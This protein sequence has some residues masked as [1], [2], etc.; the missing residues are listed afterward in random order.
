MTGVAEPIR[1]WQR[2]SDGQFRVGVVGGGSWGTT[3]AHLAAIA[4]HETRLWVRREELAREI[5]GSHRSPAYTGDV[6]IHPRVKATTDLGEMRECFL[7]LVAIP[8]QAF[9]LVVRDLGDHVD[10][11]HVVV[12]ATKG[13]E[14]MS[15]LTMTEVLLQETCCRKVGVL[16]GPNLSAEI[17]AGQPAVTV[18]GSHFPEVVDATRYGLASRQF[19]LYGNDDVVGV[20]VAGALKNVIA[21]ASGYVAGLGL[22]DNTRAGLLTRGMAEIARI[23]IHLGARERTFSG[24]SGIGDLIATC[25]SPKS[26]NFTVGTLLAEGRSLERIL[27]ELGHVAE[28]VHTTRIVHDLGRRRGLE[29]PITDAVHAVIDGEM[30]PEEVISTLMMREVGD[31]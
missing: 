4:G 8:S 20:E 19:R 17:L 13:F 21:M 16:A 10:G 14:R 6:D 25:S 22:G 1:P 15:F 26:R 27:E 23:G 18:V 24:L 3:L 11:S 29:I 31:E 9:R 5:N 12:H 30:G 28:G 2:A 7:I